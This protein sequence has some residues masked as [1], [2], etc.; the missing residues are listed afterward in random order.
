MIL[1]NAFRRKGRTVM[2]ITAVAISTALLVSMLSIAEGIMLNAT[3]SIQESKRDIIITS[4]GA[5]GIVNGHELANDLM[6]DEN[7]SHASAILGTDFQE[8]LRLNISE[9]SPGKPELAAL[10]VGVIPDDEI[11]FLS[12]ESERKL[13]DVFEIRFLD[14]FDEGGDPHYE[15]NYTGQWTYEILIDDVF[16]E[17]NNLSKGSEITI[18][19]MPHK[20]RISGLFSTVFT[21]EGAFSFDFG[22]VFMHLSELQSL[23]NL[24]DNDV[25]TSV[26]ISLAEGSKDVKSARAVAEDMKNQYPF[27]SILTRE[28][29]LNSVEDQ[30]VLARLFYTAIG[31]VSMIIGLLFVAC[32]MIMSIYERTNE[33]GMMRA[34]GIS[35]RSIFKQTIFESMVFVIIG[36][37][38]G[39]ILGY[40]GSQAFG[41]FLRTSSGLDQEFTAF[42]TS[43]LVQSLLIIIVFGTL[44]SLYPAW[45]A[46]RKNIQ[47][48]LRFIR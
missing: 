6:D 48:A 18:N 46:A 30:M 22:I 47:D 32:I 31:S 21:G 20:F 12:E 19:N 24:T 14:W 9:Y 33:F 45:Q 13:Q 2:T 44:I 26:S 34:I 15:N 39:I 16:A 4:E 17:K 27:Y 1:K 8:L 37:L 11:A 28:D 35:K 5:H 43:L 42:T 3:M 40:Y 29:R 25:V 7:V 41:D 23:L 38:I 36:A 10:G